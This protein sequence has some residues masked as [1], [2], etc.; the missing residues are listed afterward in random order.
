VGWGFSAGLFLWVRWQ[1][2][3]VTEGDIFITENVVHDSAASFLS[4]V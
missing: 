3:I 2:M 1:G 4:L